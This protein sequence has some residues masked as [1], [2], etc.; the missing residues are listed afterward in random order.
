MN[1]TAGKKSSI[2]IYKN[3][4]SILALNSTYRIKVKLI[5]PIPFGSVIG[6]AFALLG[7]PTVL[8]ALTFL[9]EV[10]F[11]FIEQY[12]LSFTDNRHDIIQ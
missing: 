12:M 7:C 10:G 5:Y 2:I 9:G 6:S 3:N 8:S 4:K 1:N 11:E